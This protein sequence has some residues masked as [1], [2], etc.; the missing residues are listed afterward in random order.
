MKPPTIRQRVLDTLAESPR[1][2]R[3][4]VIA[5]RLG[6]L[7]S[8]TRATLT[9]LHEAGQIERAGRCRWRAVQT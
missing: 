9:A 3:A 8:T 6:L 2:L 5:S 7:G 4:T 1:P